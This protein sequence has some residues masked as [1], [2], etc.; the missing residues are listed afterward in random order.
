MDRL[1]TGMTLW[2]D[3]LPGPKCKCRAWRSHQKISVQFDTVDILEDDFIRLASTEFHTLEVAQCKVCG[4]NWYVRTDQ[5][6]ENVYF[7]RISEFDSEKIIQFESWP[8]HYK[9]IDRIKAFEGKG[10]H[11]QGLEKPWQVFKHYLVET[12]RIE[13]FTEEQIVFFHYPLGKLYHK[14]S[15]MEW[16]EFMDFLAAKNFPIRK[17]KWWRVY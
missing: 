10:F 6:F 2:L 16:R 4:Q 7:E 9:A 11:G 5:D 1:K 17:K 15:D 13:L 12:T 3:S 14:C 8:M